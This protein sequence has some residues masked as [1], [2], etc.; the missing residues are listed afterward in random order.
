[1]KNEAYLLLFV[2]LVIQVFDKD[3]GLLFLQIICCILIMIIVFLEWR[4]NK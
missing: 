3:D 4:R 2:I 1:M